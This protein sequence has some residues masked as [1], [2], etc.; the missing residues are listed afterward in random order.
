MEGHRRSGEG[1]EGVWRD[2]EGVWRG[3]RVQMG[4]RAWNGCVGVQRDTDL[5]TWVYKGT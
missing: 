5:G 2:K 4:R 1:T 3:A